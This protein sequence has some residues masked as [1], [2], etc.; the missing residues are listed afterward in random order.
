MLAFRE[1]DDALGR[2]CSNERTSKDGSRALGDVAAGRLAAYEVLNEAPQLHGSKAGSFRCAALARQMD[3][4]KRDG[5]GPMNN[6]WRSPIYPANKSTRLRRFDCRV[7]KRRAIILPCV[8][9]TFINT[10][11]MFAI[12]VA[13]VLLACA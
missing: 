4:S 3:A 2:R 5:S 7:D 12:A 8:H 11:S 10:P 6:F 9:V 1:L 13:G